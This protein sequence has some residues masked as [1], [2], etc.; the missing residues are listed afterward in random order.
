VTGNTVIERSGERRLGA[1]VVGAA[2][3][4]DNVRYGRL[5]SPESA[6]MNGMDHDLQ[7]DALLRQ[8]IA[9]IQVRRRYPR[10]NPGHHIG[11]IGIVAK[12]AGLHAV[13][14]IVAVTV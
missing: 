8:V 5:P 1:E 13:H 7:V 2:A 10:T 9:G 4:I 11:C 14:A 12:G 6:G 3:M